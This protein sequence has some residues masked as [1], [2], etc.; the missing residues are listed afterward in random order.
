MQKL[1]GTVLCCLLLISAT[2]ALAYEKGM[3]ALSATMEKK[4]A[5]AGKKNVAV[6]D[7]T[8]LRGSTTELGTFLAEELSSDLS[9]DRKG[10]E[11][12]DRNNLKSILTEHKL[13]MSG[14]VD[15]KTIREL[16]RIAGVDAIITGTVTPFRHSVRVSV[17]VIATDTDKAFGAAKADIP[18][19][20][21]IEELL[22]KGIDTGATLGQQQ[23]EVKN[24]LFQLQKCRLAVQTVTCDFM[25]TSKGQD[26]KLTILGN[27][28]SRILDDMGNEFKAGNVIIGNASDSDWVSKK[29]VSNIPVKARLVFESVPSKPNLLL[30]LEIVFDGEKAQFRN[31]PVSAK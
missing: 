9:E 19:T 29:L 23:V 14:P 22:A 26:R 25:V 3:K 11:V 8:D 17:R 28:G 30:M 31:V 2:T 12:I 10:F 1:I 13:S 18:K 4:I 20:K 5:N 16:G 15:P 27:T 6:V 21:A 7:F 24:F